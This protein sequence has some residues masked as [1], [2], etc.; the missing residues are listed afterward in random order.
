MVARRSDRVKRTLFTAITVGACALMASTAW[1][2][3]LPPPEEFTETGVVS[4][5]DRAGGAP[6]PDDLAFVLGEEELRACRLDLLTGHLG[7]GTAADI[8]VQGPSGVRVNLLDGNLVWHGAFLPHGTPRS[9]LGFTLTYNARA[10]DHDELQLPIGWTHALSTQ[11]RP[12]PWGVME[13]VEHD[14]FV[15]RYYAITDE[16]FVSRD[17]LIDTLVHARR[18]NGR[19][20]GLP[21]P[22][23]ARFRRQL[24]HDDLFLEAMRARFIGGGAG[25]AGMYASQGRGH[26]VLAVEQDGSAVRRRADGRVE[27]F[28]AEGYLTEIEPATGPPVSLTRT[29]SSLEGAAVAL[30]P[31][32]R[33]TTDGE[34]RLTEIEGEAGRR[35]SLSHEAG[36]LTGIDAPRDSWRF[37]YGAHGALE[38]VDGPEGRVTISYVDGRVSTLDGPDGTTRFEYAF[39]G[40][41]IHATA[42]GPV[43]T[44]EVELDVEAGLRR[45][46]GPRGDAEV[47]FDA[48]FNRALR[49]D[50]VAFTY[51]D[52]GHVIAVSGRRGTLRV[53]RGADGWPASI[54]DATGQRVQLALD[55]NGRLVRAN[56]GAGVTQN[57]MYDGL[58]QLVREQNGAATMRIDRGLWGQIERVVTPAGDTAYLE[59]DPGGRI[60]SYRTSTGAQLR[61]EWDDGDR[62]VGAVSADRREVSVARS[63]GLVLSDARG[64]VVSFSRGRAGWLTAIE[65]THPGRRVTLTHSASG[66]LS[67]AQYGAGGTLAITHDG[68]RTSRLD[69]DVLGLV[70]FDHDGERLMAARVGSSSWAFPGGA[71]GPDRITSTAGREVALSRG[72]RGLWSGIA[73][74]LQIPYTVSRDVAGRPS[75]V[76]PTGA[77]A[78]PLA[79]DLGGRVIRVGDGDDAVLELTRDSRGQVI[80]AGRDG[81]T[82]RIT[83]GLRGWPREVESPGGESWTLAVDT[84]GRATR[85]AGPEGSPLQ[86][87]WTGVGQLIEARA[88]VEWL[89]LTY[90]DE[91]TPVRVET[92]DKPALDYAWASR[93]VGV[94]R[95][96][97]AP[98]SVLLDG[99]GRISG[100]RGS[101]RHDLG[102]GDGGQWANWT[103]D[104]QPRAPSTVLQCGDD[105]LEPGAVARALFA[106][107]LPLPR[108]SADLV[109]APLVG[110]PLPRWAVD[111]LTRST[112]PD[113]TAAIPAPPGADLSAPTAGSGRVTVAGA[114]ALTGF[115]ATDL[116]DHR[117][118]VPRGGPPITLV[119]PGLDELRALH[120]TW[121]HDPLGP[122]PTAVSLEPTGRG[123]ILHPGGAAVGHPTPWAAVD[124]PFHLVQPSLEVLGIDTVAPARGAVVPA[125]WTPGPWDTATAALHDALDRGRWLSEVPP[126][127]LAPTAGLRAQM[128]GAYPAWLAGDI[129]IVVDAQG[130]LRG[131]DLG[132][133]SAAMVN[134]EMVRRYLAS[135]V[136]GSAADPVL[137]RLWLPSPGGGPETTLGLLPGPGGVWVDGEGSILTPCPR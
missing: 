61:L 71:T 134:R 101:V 1:A 25:L 124:D 11:L 38:M 5:E 111:L 133:T 39:D 65:G 21:I 14:G 66:L 31:Q 67:R 59:R 52:R 10:T 54:T 96:D 45:V 110:P 49:A 76:N 98:M 106:P 118:L 7:L 35:L 4:D 40:P 18:S 43:A 64:R 93:E 72:P 26:Q 120:E 8:F 27:H 129:Q 73:A 56:D 108:S 53:D 94:Q 79:R 17:E 100:S 130:R 126:T 121:N 117:T 75:G 107:D 9:A 102:W 44:V 105:D 131:L 123:V 89:A 19:S 77:L 57:Y 42:T 104:G 116:S 55:G 47:A 30:G 137:P 58:G 127:A 2:K 16:Q 97:A 24:E 119:C 3:R 33:L 20:D 22:A 113:W 87:A 63:R 13:V 6:Q 81:A 37:T 109:D 23:G 114:L 90:G 122:A 68:N 86:L 88:G 60:A 82:W 15:H 48:G 74:G 78:V 128:A 103:V 84:A 83:R 29:G 115:I 135:A 125:T 51:D 12:G 80:A 99:H 112:I 36:R 85:L 69:D 70:S 62:L 92:H 28:D 136:D 32:L 46:S 50:D 41:S 34:G 91:G 132:A 95:G